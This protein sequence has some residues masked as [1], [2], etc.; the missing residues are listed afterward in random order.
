[1]NFRRHKSPWKDEYFS[2][3][4]AVDLRKEYRFTHPLGFCN[5]TGAPKPVARN[6][7]INSLLA[8]LGSHH[9]QIRPSINR[10]RFGYQTFES[11][12]NICLP[13]PTP[14]CAPRISI[15]FEIVQADVPALLGMD[16]L[17]REE[18]VVAKVFYHLA[19]RAAYDMKY[20][21][22]V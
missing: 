3:N 9:R 18:L 22:K 13:L 8:R 21:R 14:K 17:D 2:N 5:Y 4:F 10:F 16:V 7:R 6:R 19:H 11:L 15:D 1:M 20:C 12:G